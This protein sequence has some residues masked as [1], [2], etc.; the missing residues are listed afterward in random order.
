[1]NYNQIYIGG[2]W[3]YS[4]SPAMIEVENPATR[5]II[6]K[7]PAGNAKDV[8][9]AVLSA[10]AAFEAWSE[11]TLEERIVTLRKVYD[12]F[13]AKKEQLIQMEVAEL[14]QPIRWAERAHVIGP[15]ARFDNY[16]KLIQD[17]HFEEKLKHA[18]ISREPIGVIGCITP[19]N[20]PLG[21]VMQK[22]VPALLTGNTVVLKPSQMTPLSAMVLAESFHEAGVPA[23]VFNLVTGRGAEVG[24]ALALHPDVQMI[25]FTGSTTGGRE[26]GKLALE[27][28]KKI[29]LELGGKSPLIV[30]PDADI[31][32]AVDT[33]ISSC[34]DN[35]GQT[36]AALTRM[37]IPKADKEKIESLIIERS[38][39]YTV[40]DPTL[41]D[42]KVGPLASAKQ[43]KKVS[44][45]IEIGIEEGAKLI[46]G[47]MPVPYE[48]LGE[49]GYYVKPTVFTDVENH[50]KIAQEEIFGPVISLIAY[51]TVEDAIRIANDV[52]YGL[53]GAVI[54]PWD[55]ANEVATKIKTG[56][57]YV[58][59]GKRDINAPFGGYKQS[60][61][62][63]E[64]GIQGIEEFLEIKS[65]FNEPQ[66]EKL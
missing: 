55:L 58:N 3:V 54:G 48:A 62:G 27:T 42:T 53:S 19:W 29:A 38:K 32:L 47:E 57:V 1:M 37:I 41:V 56:S 4:D 2:E 61:I 44:K 33:V 31:S 9:R 50:M 14:G 7:V 30:L 43:Y 13:A 25:S 59:D 21:Q 16:I 6:G 35:T 20:Y 8:D 12:H 15:L 28:I 22:I 60:G 5:K 51:D 26:V 10:K 63:R 64:G 65:I 46:V 49:N 18:T 11:T 24:N 45:Y 23:G 34:F 39:A 40:G 52:P 66:P 36:C 17:Y